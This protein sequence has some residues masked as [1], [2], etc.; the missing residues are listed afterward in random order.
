MWAVDWAV[1]LVPKRHTIS[2]ALDDCQPIVQLMRALH[3]SIFH[4]QYSGIWSECDR[5]WMLAV[6]LLSS[7]PIRRWLLFDVY[8]GSGTNQLISL[9][10]WG[11][12]QQTLTIVLNFYF[13]LCSLAECLHRPAALSMWDPLCSTDCRYFPSMNSLPRTFWRFPRCRWRF[14]TKKERER[15][16]HTRPSQNVNGRSVNEKHIFEIKFSYFNQ[17]KSS[18]IQ[19]VAPEVVCPVTTI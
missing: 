2:R 8:C 6:R 18:S 11:Y 12:G 19:Q 4:M 10:E 15:D 9:E 17:S 1:D 16:T 5:Q 7:T 3:W 14:T 13:D